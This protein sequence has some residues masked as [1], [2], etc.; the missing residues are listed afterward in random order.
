MSRALA[1]PPITSVT[2]TGIL[3]ALADPVRLQIIR[4]L[5]RNGDGMSCTQT[6][7][8]LGL[9][10]PKSTCSQHYRILREAG[11]IVSER[12]GTELTSRVRFAELQVRFPGLLQSILTSYDR[13]APTMPR[14]GEDGLMRAGEPA[15]AAAEGRGKRAREDSR[16][17]KKAR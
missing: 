3:H 16:A 7:T 12:H 10:T 17:S 2:V 6:T 14:R 8:R 5:L 4:E 11:L 15:T 9:G 1:H 13:E